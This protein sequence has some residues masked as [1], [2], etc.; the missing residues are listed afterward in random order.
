MPFNCNDLDDK[1]PLIYCSVGSHPDYCEHRMKLF[2]AVLE[3]V[4]QRPHLQAIIQIIDKSEREMFNPLPD[5]VIISGWVPQL[6][7]LARSHIFITHGGFSSIRESLYSGVPMIVFPFLNDGF[8][9]SARCV[10]HHL[11][12]RGDIRKV[13]PKIVEKLIDKICNDDSYHRSVKRM[14]KIF[15]EQ[16]NCKKGID[17]IED[18]I[19]NQKKI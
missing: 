16:E 6:E 18:L 7:V 17:F 9:N 2:S 8:G 3:A 5:N 14:Q 11:A 10:F 15:L 12:L 4:K 1:K 19:N 13:T